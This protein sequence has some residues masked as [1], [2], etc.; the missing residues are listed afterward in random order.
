MY[1]VIVPV[2]IKEGFKE[3]FVEEIIG[4]AKGSVTNE[5]GCLRFDVIQD[6]HDPNRIWLYEVY[7]DEAAFQAHTEAPHFIRWRDATKGWTE[8][9]S[10]KPAIGC[11]NIWPRDEDWG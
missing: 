4:D 11:A 9:T 10:T 2:Q 3:R 5:P 8:E 1:V 7:R 6:C